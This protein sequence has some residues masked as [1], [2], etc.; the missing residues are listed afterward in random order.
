MELGV[1]FKADSNGHIT[2]IRFY[3]S[4]ANTGT[5]RKFVEQPAL[6]VRHV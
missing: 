6:L 4:A 2:G 5:H 1:T 3:K